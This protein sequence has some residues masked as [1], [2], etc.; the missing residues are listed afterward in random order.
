M[1]LLG[2]GERS[3]A[4]R[5]ESTACPVKDRGCKARWIVPRTEDQ[6]VWLARMLVQRKRPTASNRVGASGKPSISSNPRQTAAGKIDQ[7]KRSA[8]HYLGQLTSGQF[9][10]S[11]DVLAKIVSRRFST[12]ERLD[13]CSMH[14]GR[15]IQ[16]TVLSIG[17]VE[18]REAR[19]TEEERPASYGMTAYPWTD[20]V[21]DG[22][23][24]AME[25]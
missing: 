25:V 15:D 24:S 1:R 11:H 17:G 14:I 3:K 21:D 10:H 20:S 16:D 4:G 5:A 22:Q 13:K 23:L 6:T 8:R 2:I 19:L 18:A 7:P 9:S 12:A